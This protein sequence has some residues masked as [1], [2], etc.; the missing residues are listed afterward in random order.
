MSSRNMCYLT[1]F[2]FQNGIYQTPTVGLS[3]WKQKRMCR[4][5]TTTSGVK[6]GCFTG[7]IYTVLHR[8]IS[9]QINR[10]S[11]YQ[12]PQNSTETRKFCSD[13]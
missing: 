9:D 4:M 6:G 13:G 7:F 5:C 1:G 8:H 12:I 11:F 3:I 2:Y 10:R